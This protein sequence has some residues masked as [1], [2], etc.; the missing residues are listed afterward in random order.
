MRTLAFAIASL[1]VAAAAVTG[2]P[3]IAD[4]AT[5]MQAPGTMDVAH[6]AAGTYAADP[7]HTLV[8]WR[9][10]HLG[11]NDYFG[12]FGNIEGTLRLDPEDPAA[13]SLSVTIPVAEVTVASEG[14]KEHLFRPAK[15]GT[16]PDFFGPLP[17]PA[18]FV[19]TAIAIEHGATEG[20]IS[21]DLT[22]NGITKPVTIAAEFTGAGTNPLSGK[23]TVGF[24]GRTTI[25]RSQF[26]IG[27]FAPLVSDEVELEITAAFEKE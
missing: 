9:L 26:G 25:R 6:V 14:L 4:S 24:E 5:P 27:A 2:I 3:A 8:G 23:Q 12:I 18:T 16:E 1:T 20:K 22:L 13:A 10:N 15:D 21:G 11:F 17:E 7:A 19:S